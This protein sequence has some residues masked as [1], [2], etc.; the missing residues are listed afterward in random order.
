MEQQNTRVARLS[1]RIKNN[2][3]VASLI[4]LG[5]F[6]IALSTFTDA[7]NKLFSVISKQSPQAARIQLGQMSL[8]YTPKAFI[9]S[10]QTGDL[11]A[12]KLF[13]A[14]GMDPNAT[15]AEGGTALRFAAY[16]GHTQIVA[17][18]VKA[19]AAIEKGEG[20]RTALFSA[21]SGGHI[22][23]L[24]VLLDKSPDAK[25]IND[26]FIEAARTR[27]HEAVRVL[28]DI[29]ADVKKV[30]SPAMIIF[31]LGAVGWG[32]EE[33][34][35]TVRFLLN[36]GADPNG[37]DEEG[38]TALLAA[39]HLGYPSVVR[40]LLD[41]GADVNAKCACPGWV[42]GGWTA[43]LLA[44]DGRH[45]E[46]VEAL[47]DKGADV[48]QR[49][50]L[51]KSALLIAAHEGDERI[52]KAV[53]DRNVD[54]NEKD[55]GGQTALVVLAAGTRW[56]DGMV[57]DHPDAVRALLQKG[58][59]I[60]ERDNAGRTALMLAAQSGSTSVVRALL[61]KGARVT[62]KDADGKTP[63]DFARKGSNAGK[64]TEVIHL[65]QK[66]GAK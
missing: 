19:G 5:S 45:M 23:S 58:A 25:T 43:L 49:N 56:P 39:A 65:L 17:A 46:V 64:A 29:G 22:E 57:V 66:P 24:R 35:D 33:V 30:G 59:Q 16:S 26:A 54:V 27:H 3:V 48:N 41:R 2:P 13:L 40:L 32:E 20:G 55:S 51:G 9:L 37:K 34:S 44:T 18:L 50:N 61:E 21:A 31:L 4:I 10:A 62:D 1:S 47:L 38:W 15:D 7:T 53:L 8:P 63:L 11:A 12:V 6:V 52:F 42:N 28:A 60:N 36:L 14:A